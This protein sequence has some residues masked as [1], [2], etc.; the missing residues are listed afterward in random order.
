MK[1]ALFTL[2]TRLAT[3]GI[4]PGDPDEVRL[5]KA[6][7]SLTAALISVMGFIWAGMYAALGLYRGAAI[8]FAYAA[9][10]SATLPLAIATNRFDLFRLGQ[11][12]MMT[13]LPFLLQWRLGGIAYSGAVM[14]W[15]F[16]T[17]LYA[18]ITGGSR[19]WQGWLAAFVALVAVSGALEPQDAAAA[20]PIAPALSV[21]FIVMNVGGLA[22]VTMLLMRY[23]VRERD[24]AQRR[25]EQ[26]LLNI[27]PRPIAQRLKRDP[28]AIA[29]G[30]DDVSVL[31]A[32]VVD[33][34]IYSANRA[35][36]Q[37]VEMLNDLFTE[38]DQLAERLGLE[39]IKTV[40]DAYMA[41]AG[42]P[43]SRP[44]HAEAAA[45]MALAMQ[46]VMT[47]R[48]TQSG[49]ALQLRIGIHSGPVVASVIG[50]RKFI[51]D[52]WG[53]HGEYGEPHG[54]T[55]PAGFDSG[56]DRHLRAP[57]RSL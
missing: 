34:T 27:L 55:R 30:Y 6:T 4:R 20:P 5:Q 10:S 35:P 46:Q 38:F 44:D 56:H 45:E 54:V 9:I 16:W 13:V 24:E 32:D 19:E 3:A 11:L 53:G 1:R 12:V 8:P 25:S 22:L 42:L 26:L 23:V 50:R 29:D 49:D 28:A 43:A 14:V 18:L 57:A 31:F 2:I 7:V 51:Y 33:F 40:G 47:R 36:R 52:L 41:V 21:I 39:K 17:P 15:A 48:A 37:L